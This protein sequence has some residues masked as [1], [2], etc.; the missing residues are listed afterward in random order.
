MRQQFIEQIV[1]QQP[2]QSLMALLARPCRLLCETDQRIQATMEIPAKVLDID[3]L[4]I[5]GQVD[6]FGPE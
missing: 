2:L 1:C 6:R 4:A 3:N 5:V